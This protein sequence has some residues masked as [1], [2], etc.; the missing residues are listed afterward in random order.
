MQMRQSD[1]LSYMYLYTISITVQWLEVVYKIAVSFRFSE[2]SEEDL[3][4]LLDLL[5]FLLK[6]LDYLLSISIMWYHIIEI[7]SS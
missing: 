6:Q 7:S 1:W 5:W 3:E 4:L 2:D